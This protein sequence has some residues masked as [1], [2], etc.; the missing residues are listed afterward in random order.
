MRARKWKKILALILSM[1]LIFGMIPE[2]V[3]EVKAAGSLTPSQDTVDFSEVTVG[4]GTE[5]IP[6]PTPIAVT[7]TNNTGSEVVITG[8]V[9]QNGDSSNFI[10][11]NLPE[12]LGSGVTVANEGIVEFNVAPKDG[13]GV[14]SDEYTD[15]IKVNYTENSTSKEI[16]IYVKIKIV[17]VTYSVTFEGGGSD[18][19]EAPTMAA[20]AASATFNLP[21]NTFTK[22]GYVFDKWSDGSK[23]YAVG[24]EFTMPANAVTFTATWIAQTSKLEFTTSSFTMQDAS[25]TAA[26]YTLSATPAAGSTF[27][28]YDTESST[29]ELGSEVASVTVSESTLTLT[30]GAAPTSNA[31]YYIT[32]TDRTASKAESERVRVDVIAYAKSTKP[33]TSETD[34]TKTKETAEA[35]SVAFGMTTLPEGTYKVY[36]TVAGATVPTGVTATKTNATTLTLTK[37]EGNSLPAGKYYITVTVSGKAESDR[38]E[39]T[40]SDPLSY[41]ITLKEGTANSVAF[42]LVS[43]TTGQVAA[44]TI[45]ITNTGTGAI[46]SYTIALGGTNADKFELSAVSGSAIVAGGTATFTVQPVAGLDASENEYTATITVTTSPTQATGNTIPVSI[47]VNRIDAAIS[48]ADSIPDIIADNEKITAGTDSSKDIVYTYT[49]DGAVTVTWYNDNTNAIGTSLGEGAENAPSAAGTY[50]IG[51]KAAQ[52][53]NYN[54]VTEVQ[55]QFKIVNKTADL[56][57]K[58]NKNDYRI[59]TST[60]TK[61]SYTLDTALLKTVTCKVYADGT[62]SDI[63][64][65]VTAVA[66]GSALTLTFETSPSVETSYYVSVQ[67]DGEVESSRVQVIVKHY[68]Q[69]T[70]PAATLENR[71]KALDQASGQKSIEFTLSTAPS[72]TYKVY[73]DNTTNS[74]STRATVSVVGKTLTLT[75][76]SSADIE[77]GT[78]YVSV[79]E[80]D[81][82]AESTRLELTVTAP[83]TYGIT[84]KEGENTSVTF[85]DLKY[86]YTQ[87]AAKT[88]TIANTGTGQITSYTIALS[89]SGSSKFTLSAV[90]G[91]AIAVGGSGSFTVK[92]N[93]GL[94][95]GT[96]TADITVT[97]VPEVTTGNVITVSFT[98]GLAD[99]TAPVLSDD[100][101]TKTHNSITMPALTGGTYYYKKSSDNDSTYTSAGTNTISGLD[102]NTEYSIKAQYNATATHSE[103]GDSNVITITTDAAPVAPS[104]TTTTLANGIVGVE[105]SVALQAGGTSPITWTLKGGSSL[106]DGLTLTTAGVVSGSPLSVTVVSGATFTVVATN[107]GGSDEEELT[108]IIDPALLIN[109]ASVAEAIAGSSYSA[110]LEANKSGATWSL[111]NGAPSWLSIGSA[112]GT[113][114]GT[115]PSETGTVNITA[116]ASKGS[117][118]AT[119]ALTITIVP[120]LVIIQTQLPDVVSGGAYT[121]TL[122]ANKTGVTWSL[123]DGHPTWLSIDSG[124]GVLSGTAP[125]AP[126]T[127]DVTIKVSKG[128]ETVSKTLQIAIVSATIGLTDVDNSATYGTGSSQAYTVSNAGFGVGAFAPYIEWQTAEGWTTTDPTGMSGAF[129]NSN[130]TLTISSTAAAAAKPYTFR[131]KSG[132]YHSVSA[133][134]VINQKAATLSLPATINPILSGTGITVGT[135]ASDTIQCT[136]DGDGQICAKYYGADGSGNKG[137]ELP[138]V[139]SAVGTYYIEVWA[140]E[141]TNYQAVAAITAKQFKIMAA[142]SITT[143]GS[144]ADGSIGVAYSQTLEANN[145]GGT[146]TWTKAEGDL[147]AGLS[148]TTA[149][150]ITGTPESI[151]NT[152][153]YQFKV[154]ATNEVGSVTSSALSIRVKA[155]LSGTVTID[156]AKKYGETLIAA[157]SGSSNNTGVLSYTWK[158]GSETIP[159]AI[160]ASYQL[161][162]DDITKTITCEI[163]SSIETGSIRATTVAIDKADAPAAPAAP[164]LAGKTNNSITVVATTGYQ[165]SKDGTNWQDE[166]VFSGLSAKQTISN[167]YARVK[168][169]ATRKASDSSLALS[170]VTTNEF[171]VTLSTIGLSGATAGYDQKTNVVSGSSIILTIAPNANTSF[172]ATPIVTAAGGTAGTVTKSGSN[173]TCTISGITADL[174]ITVSGSTTS[175]STGG[176]GG[177]GYTP[178]EPYTPPTEPTAVPTPT[179]APTATPAPLIIIDEPEKEDGEDKQGEQE[180]APKQATLVT[181]SKVVVEEGKATVESNVSK[182]QLN[183]VKEAVKKAAEDAKK[184]GTSGTEAAK[185]EVSLKLPEEDLVKQMKDKDVKEIVTS[186][187]I[188]SDFEKETG[189]DLAGITLPS[190]VLESAGESKKDVTVELKDEKGNLKYAWNFPADELAN[191]ENKNMDVN[192]K[193]DI[194]TPKDKVLENVPEETKKEVEKNNGLVINF[195]HSGDLPA[196]ATV[197]I[198]VSDQNLKPGD[199]VHMY[200][201]NDVTGMIE[202]LPNGTY[203]VNADG[204]VDVAITHCSQYFLVSEPMANVTGIKDQVKAVE[205]L[206][207]F[208]G[209]TLGKTGS[210][211]PIAPATFA[212]VTK[213]GQNTSKAKEELIVKY[214]SSN[215]KVATVDASGKVKAVKA[216]TAEIT[217]TVTFSDGTKKTLTTELTVTKAYAVILTAAELENLTATVPDGA[218]K[219]VLGDTAEFVAVLEG[220]DAAG[221]K[222]M[223]AR[224]NR[225][226]VGKNNGK[227][228]AVVSTSTTGTDTLRLLLNGKEIATRTVTV[229]AKQTTSPEQS[230]TETYVIQ[231]GDSLFIISKKYKVTVDQLVEWNKIKDPNY[232][233]AG[234][235][236]IIKK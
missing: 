158:R 14:K 137:N 109:T 34:A 222:W 44:K 180:P 233:E 178:Y 67:A 213:K 161:G 35:S 207:L 151:A 211:K 145:G 183:A 236:L 123:E 225:A 117:E 13:L 48:M 234:E 126:P 186:M 21:G 176:G 18:D 89:G 131:V 140:E 162:V 203:T 16:G 37:S 17:P 65:G 172:S 235:K 227:T 114:T 129:S 146:V 6:T 174:T 175:T 36:D 7:I 226:V 85:S 60:G 100:G 136:Y 122:T 83:L 171:A 82:K 38:L 141:G 138:G 42:G 59:P 170:G 66:T 231:P 142:P 169:T 80:T 159:N 134:Y 87:P 71:T 49:G 39:L 212:F 221:I 86:G 30:L 91:G 124:T 19:G 155:V 150:A 84:L 29:P 61:A 107:A 210:V 148:L 135:G 74:E 11:S 8:I 76:K 139:P 97:T 9:L 188:P 216:G 78:Y 28:V 204:T 160:S 208:L 201:Y 70:A 185:L 215:K 77:A 182:E 209:G 1:V 196:T 56:S 57:F 96:Y 2:D 118:T 102:A 228:E 154:K 232:I 202:E 179:T 125:A 3:V 68:A 164:V 193:L 127:V 223:T 120:A 104:I 149:G 90:S 73:D 194:V 152:T 133:T 192:L 22:T 75:G 110:T 157:V 92:P 168:E 95:V 31:D 10:L 45:T 187:T 218:V 69:S 206:E 229:T 165:Y 156:G 153:T 23:T 181:E 200:Y 197:K 43:Y 62:T 5:E 53:T 46:D 94:A 63:A 58:D 24:E 115:V 144:L 51:V 15:T 167:I 108:L 190:T 4:Y 112:S 173:Y 20:Q 130:A 98:V 205:V 106:P 88:V 50:W 214:A 128:T 64:T 166:A 41:T 111:Q 143:S 220:Y 99:K 52:G 195:S 199:T 27:K 116:I 47:T 113:L 79:T 230:K 72:G 191:S 25:T 105:Y 219:L 12:N 26:T 121:T 33:E 32:V 101:V 217:T 103:S 55:K 184:A 119:K 40:V 147:P 132:E 198:N 54:A 163:S 81:G 177:G 224:R 189:A 93:A